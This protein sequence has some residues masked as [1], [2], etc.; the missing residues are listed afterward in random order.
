MKKNLH[1]D[2]FDKLLRSKFHDESAAPPDHL[3]S[4]IQRNIA[5]SPA[6]KRSWIRSRRTQTIMI[7]S[8]AA[9]LSGLFIFILHPEPFFNAPVKKTLGIGNTLL[10]DTSQNNKGNLKENHIRTKELTNTV[11][12]QIKKPVKQ[13][14]ASQNLSVKAG[15]KVQ[16]GH[17]KHPAPLTLAGNIRAANKSISPIP[18]K[19][20]SLS[21]NHRNRSTIKEA[22][23]F[24]LIP[25]NKSKFTSLTRKMKK[26]SP[27]KFSKEKLSFEIFL[28]PE[29]TYRFLMPNPAYA[30]NTFST[31]YFNSREKYRFTYSFGV[32]AGYE[33]RPEFVI[34]T[35]LSYYSYSISFSTWSKYLIK[36]SPQNWIIYTSSGPVNLFFS[37]ID[38]LNAQSLLKS[39][40]K[41]S[42]LSI[43]VILK[44]YPYKTLFIDAGTSLDFMISQ[45]DRWNME[46]YNGNF[47]IQS[48]K[49]NGTSRFNLSLIFGIGYEGPVS[50]NLSFSVNPILR[51]H[52]MN[53]N[54]SSTVKAFPYNAGFRL[55]L[56]YSLH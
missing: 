7:L 52:L 49:I 35:G 17:K 31:S 36:N 5:V 23:G 51:I 25:A 18:N 11:K 43:P 46:N 34:E 9:I 22:T 44:F 48:D 37:Q 53:L 42:Y 45:N 14:T 1:N 29:Y 32:L 12:I 54:K 33:L 41:F 39:S 47:E 28:M 26:K 3:W 4:K 15:E 8:A 21:T 10:K 50:R 6:A 40:I 2:S 19:G 56:K 24:S 13:V 38:S 16:K 30:Q 20:I 27:H 55:S